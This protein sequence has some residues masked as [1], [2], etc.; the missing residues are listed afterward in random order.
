MQLK[1]K[2]IEVDLDDPTSG[3]G[4]L[5]GFAQV[6]S[7]DM[8][9]NLFFQSETLA[10]AFLPTSSLDL[11][12]SDEMLIFGG[13]GWSQGQQFEWTDY[14]YLM[15][16][17][18]STGMAKPAAIG[19]VPGYVLNQFAM[20]FFDNH[21][22]VATTNSAKWGIT[23]S[24]T[25]EWGQISPS[26]NQV[27]VLEKQGNEFKETGKVT[28]LGK[29][30]SI[31]AVRFLGSRGFVVTF[32]TTDPLYTLDLSDPLNPRMV[33]E[34]KIP[35]FSNYLHPVDDNYLLAVGQDA[36]SKTGA[37]LGLQIS[38]FDIKDLANPLQ[39][40]KTVVEG[41]SSSESQYDHHA[42]RYLPLSKVLILPVSDY[43]NSF[44]G[45]Y[46]Y[47]VDKDN[48][49]N[50]LGEVV[51]AD[52]DFFSHY[53]CF[54]SVYLEPRS[55]VFESQLITLKGHTVEMSGNLRYPEEQWTIN[56]DENM[57]HIKCY[58]W[59]YWI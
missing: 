9:S 2:N 44:D 39:L 37:L 38:L 21:L 40:Q 32:R 51:H 57:S 1:S 33:G 52:I 12:A 6:L 24:T 13:R 16:F 23:N 8:K 42:F 36:N 28:D 41:W 29:G 47:E 7:F 43:K 31:Y 18:L 34:L 35:G 14:T 27:F 19:V 30:E 20:D 49:I 53:N 59:F 4:I 56:L 5:N 25:G 11:Y 54:S 10:G 26:E 22:R 58:P 15:G 17:D 55:L 3:S 50:K 48:G 46:I 45:F